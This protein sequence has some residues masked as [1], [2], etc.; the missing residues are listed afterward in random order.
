[1]IKITITG[2]RSITDYKTVKSILDEVLTQ[3][4]EFCINIGD[5]KGVDEQVVSYCKKN[6]IDYQVYPADWKKYNK[7][8]GVI[9]NKEMVENSDRGIAIW[10]GK[11]RGTLN[12][13]DYL[14]TYNKPVSIFKIKKQM[15]CDFKDEFGCIYC[16]EKGCEE[17]G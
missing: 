11:S 6:N 14:I 8:A 16:S 7:V 2:S 1:M 15:N 4:S 12:T 13:I 3:Y 9:R 17:R 10:D 5:A